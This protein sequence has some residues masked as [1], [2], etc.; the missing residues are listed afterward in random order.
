MEKIILYSK[1]N[2]SLC[3]RAKKILIEKKVKFETV[4]FEENEELVLSKA[5]EIRNVNMPFAEIDGKLLNAQ[6]TMIYIENI[7]KEN[8]QN[9]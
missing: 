2:C 6:N 9:E 7:K 4:M 1:K 3:E 8:V 5:R